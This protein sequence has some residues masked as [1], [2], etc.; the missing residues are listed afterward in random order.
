V[1]FIKAVVEA[2]P[3]YLMGVFKL[4]FLVCDDLTKLVRNFYLRSKG[5]KRKTHWRSWEKL[6]RPKCQGGLG[7]RD[8]RVVNQALLAR[9][10]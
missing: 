9:Q 2:L 1:V 4:P 10:A 7:F 6:Q 5:G 8:F 3:T